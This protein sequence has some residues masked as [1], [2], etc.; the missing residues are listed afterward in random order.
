[1]SYLVLARKYRPRTFAD[2]VGQEVAMAT[3]RGAIQEQRVGHAYVFSGP[4]GT[5]KTTSA[6][7]FA[8]ALN[9]ERGPTAEPCGVCERC[10]EADRGADADIIEIDAASNTGVDYARDLKQTASTGTYRARFKIFIIDEAH[11]LSK[12]AF[13]ALL[14][15]LEEPPSHAKFFLATTEPSKLLDTIRSRCQ[16]VQLA[17]LTERAIADRLTWVFEQ[18]GVKPGPGV[19]DEI[20]KRAKGGMR[21]ALSMADQLLS[22][23][24]SEPVQADVERLAGDGGHETLEELFAHVE[25]K[26][27]A[28]VLAALASIDGGQDEFLDRLLDHVRGCLVAAICG[29]N[30]PILA[31]DEATRARLAQRGERIGAARLQVWLE[32]L[33]T[34]RERIRLLPGQAQI[35]LEVVLLDLCR[36]ETDVTLSEIERRLA[37]LADRVGGGSPAAS[38]RESSAAPRALPRAHTAPP[39][40]ASVV[41]PHRAPAA[42]PAPDASQA[43]RNHAPS[44]PPRAPDV[45]TRGPARSAPS[46]APRTNDGAARADADT[47]ERFLGSLQ[48]ASLAEVLR[49]RGRLTAIEDARVRV[50]LVDV[51]PD[52]RTLLREPRNMKACSAAMTKVLGRA[53]DVVLEDDAPVAVRDDQDLFTGQVSDLFA[54]RIEDEG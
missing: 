37:Q 53:S 31:A 23:V 54:G 21:D 1:M 43:A 28:G 22:L 46:A 26:D 25:S 42:R 29:A 11:M 16:M 19:A 40:S 2:V 9:C 30:T 7:I 51:K 39:S 32:E 33:L 5:G 6:R 47:W 27:A 49:A 41:T 36:P 10:V 24:G 17:P 50:R 12:Q 44:A 14:K 35:A 15:T 45:A 13:N 20:A 52:E 4:R 3:L 48:S 8:K 34:A 38:A 18:E